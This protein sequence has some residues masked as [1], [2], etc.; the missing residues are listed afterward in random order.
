MS[1]DGVD[2][3]SPRTGLLLCRESLSNSQGP[4][5]DFMQLAEYKDLLQRYLENVFQKVLDLKEIPD[6]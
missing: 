2:I 6:S 4:F 3:D 5:A 1:S